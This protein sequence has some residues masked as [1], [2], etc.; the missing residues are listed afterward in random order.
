MCPIEE[1]PVWVTSCARLMC[2]EWAKN[3]A[4]GFAYQKFGKGV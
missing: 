4:N 3:C 1:E 2:Y